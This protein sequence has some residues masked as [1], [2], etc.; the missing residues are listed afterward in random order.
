MWTLGL[1]ALE[2]DEIENEKPKLALIGIFEKGQTLS[3]AEPPF[4]VIT[5][6]KWK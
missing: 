1:T 2:A 3:L 5:F 6:E 4:P